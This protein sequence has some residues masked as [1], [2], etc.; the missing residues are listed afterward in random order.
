MLRLTKAQALARLKTLIVDIDKPAI[1]IYS[2]P[3]F[4]KW[5]RDVR[6]A[7][8]YIFGKQSAH[9]KEFL[10]IK[11]RPSSSSVFL[12][13]AYNRGLSRSK[14]LLQSMA[15]EVQNF[16]KDEVTQKST[17]KPKEVTQGSGSQP[18]IFLGHGRSR[19]WARLQVFLQNDLQLKTLS[20]ESEPRTG[21]S[22]VSILEQM[23]DKAT[24]AVLVLTAE[25]LTTSG[26]KRARQNVIH[27]AGLFQGRLGFKKAVLL[28]Q[29][30]LEEFSN[31]AGLQHLSFS[32]DNIE[33]TFWEL[34][35][36]LKREK[37]LR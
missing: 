17:Q 9:L 25:D 10:A 16:W 13:D 7:I 22:I 4:T 2:S 12:Y 24:F 23:L 20:Y 19:L 33:S 18:C 30:G 8:T 26:K 35:R 21:D 37:H 27:E 31:V 36:V 1:K 28:V 11:F 32:G 29:E 6:V 3:A 14:A 5:H 34:Q 15:D